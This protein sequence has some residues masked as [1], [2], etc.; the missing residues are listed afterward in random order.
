MMR[1]YF[2]RIFILCL[3]LFAFAL[4]P[5]QAVASEVSPERSFVSVDTSEAEPYQSFGITISLRNATG[6]A[7][8][9]VPSGKV[10]IWATDSAGNVVNHLALIERSLPDGVY[11]HM[12]S[13]DGVIIMDTAALVRDQSFNLTLGRKGTYEL[14]ALFSE[15]GN[16]TTDAISSYWPYELSSGSVEARQLVVTAT[17]VRDVKA[18]NI[19]TRIN[20]VN[21][22]SIFVGGRSNLTASKP[23]SIDASGLTNTEVSV[24][25]LRSN[26]QNVGEGVPVYIDSSGLIASNMLVYTDENGVARFYVKGVATSSAE[27]R[28]R[29]STGETPVTFK[30]KSYQYRPEQVRFDIGAKQMDVDGRTVTMDTASVIKNGRTYVPFRAIGELLGARVEYDNNVRTITT[31]FDDSVLTMSV[32]Y[33]NYAVDGVVHQMDAAPYINGDGRTMVPI[34]FVAQVIGY[35]VQAVTGSNNLTKSVIFTR[36]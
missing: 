9:S 4:A 12:T 36:Q 33:N 1:R 28:L 20:G 31:Y 14:H 15:E 21:V 5:S 11:A 16:L 32:G 3:A 6:L 10:Y 17:P 2:S 27:V 30:V 8:N 25:L 26:G 7:L 18:M 19:S 13:T 29:C 23:I 34:R 22:D 35:D 24:T